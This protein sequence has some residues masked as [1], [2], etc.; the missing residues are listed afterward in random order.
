MQVHMSQNLTTASWWCT[1]HSRR[2]PDTSV[3]ADDPFQSQNPP[4]SARRHNLLLQ[5]HDWPRLCYP[6]RNWFSPQEC[7]I[8][9]MLPALD[10]WVRTII[11]TIIKYGRTTQVTTTTRFWTSQRPVQTR[12][13]QR[14][15]PVCMQYCMLTQGF[16]YKLV[17]KQ[18]ILPNDHTS[19]CS[20]LF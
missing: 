15:R 20:K 16:S 8:N 2:R 11:A 1:T 7:E 13:I 9:F 19:I 14:P 6:C 3:T 17:G 18:H 12:I 5:R 4:D 10:A